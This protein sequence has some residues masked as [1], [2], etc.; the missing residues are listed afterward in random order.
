[1][2][3]ADEIHSLL[4][5]SADLDL[6]ARSLIEAAN[7]GGGEDNITVV[8]F[9]I[10]DRGEVEQTAQIPVA[11]P[12]ADDDEDTLSGLEQVPA[13]DTAVIP[14]AVVEE[15]LQQLEAAPASRARAAT[16]AP[17][18]HSAR[19]AARRDRPARRLGAL[20]LSLRNRELLNLI[21]VG[22]LT[23]IGFASVYIAR[24]SLVDAASLTYA[25]IFFALYLAAHLVARLAVP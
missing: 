13:V 23:A 7:A 10:G 4:A 1:M 16:E 6:A 15:Q 14:A 17:A 22:L 9:Q 19:R 25:G 11:G 5:D 3:S 21:A 24:S 2:I 8:L 20:A 18:A 12:E